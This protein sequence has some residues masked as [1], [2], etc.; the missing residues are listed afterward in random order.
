VRTVSESESYPVSHSL[1]GTD[2]KKRVDIDPDIHNHMVVD[3]LS[4]TL[5]ALSDPTRRA[6]LNRLARREASVSELAEPFRISQ[7]AIS[8]HLTYLQ[9]ARLIRKRREGR[10]HF[11][12]LNPAPFDEVEHWIE[13]CRRFWTESFERLDKVL[14]EMKAAQS[15]Q[16]P[17]QS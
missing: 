15:Q 9:R 6:I 8:K 11:C 1:P 12:S 2:P 14:E 5:A 13:H 4:A 7:Q 17:K 10:Q 16:L 3:S